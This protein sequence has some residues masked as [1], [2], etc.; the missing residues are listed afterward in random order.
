MSKQIA[1]AIDLQT[2]RQAAGHT[3]TDL[4]ESL[5]VS[6]WQISKYESGRFNIPT[7]QACEVALMYDGIT[8]EYD[9]VELEL[10]P[11][12][13]SLQVPDE[14]L[15]PVDSALDVTKELRDVKDHM[16]SLIEHASAIRKGRCEGKQWVAIGVKEVAE[17]VAVGK[18]FLRSSKGEFPEEWAQGM[19]MALS[20]LADLY[21]VVDVE[22]GEPSVA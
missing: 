5:G 16:E 3:Q 12:R 1:V 7:P 11:K 19:A 4:G 17:L 22:I 14:D 2:K 6:M 13:K 21:G 18:R 9:G 10:R 20:E 8:L 15:K